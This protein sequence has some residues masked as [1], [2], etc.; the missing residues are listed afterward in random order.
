MNPEAQT[1]AMPQQRDGAFP[2]NLRDDPSLLAH[3]NALNGL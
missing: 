3:A 1:T 2:I